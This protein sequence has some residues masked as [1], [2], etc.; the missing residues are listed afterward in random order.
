MTTHYK[1]LDLTICSMHTS[2]QPSQ[3][4][5]NLSRANAKKASNLLDKDKNKPPPLKDSQD[6]GKSKYCNYNQN[7][8]YNTYECRR[9]RRDI[10]ALS[11]K[12][13]LN[14]F[15]VYDIFGNQI[16]EMPNV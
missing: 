16:K 5:N 12:Y 9:L 14:K 4:H 6:R 11:K 8:E 15:V 10:E 7:H 1:Y 2:Q 3:Q 13:Y